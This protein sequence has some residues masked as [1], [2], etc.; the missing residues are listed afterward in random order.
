[1]SLHELPSRSTASCSFSGDL[2]A[3]ALDTNDDGIARVSVPVFCGRLVERIAAEALDGWDDAL[4]DTDY[5]RHLSGRCRITAGA[6][7]DCHSGR[8]RGAFLQRFDPF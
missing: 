7:A 3:Y 5:A 1:M 2:D 4:I 6:R 8:S